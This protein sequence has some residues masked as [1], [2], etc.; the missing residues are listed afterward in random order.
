MT[1]L[2]ARLSESET[3]AAG[4][5]TTVDLYLGVIVRATITDVINAASETIN[6]I[7][8]FSR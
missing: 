5:R 1:E 7:F 2:W 6:S 3:E 8:L 4:N